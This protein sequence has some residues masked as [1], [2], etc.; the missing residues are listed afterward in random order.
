MIAFQIAVFISHTRW[1]KKPGAYE[2]SGEIAAAIKF[3]G[4]IPIIVQCKRDFHITLILLAANGS[5]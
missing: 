3:K 1:Q 5:A 2:D 4:F